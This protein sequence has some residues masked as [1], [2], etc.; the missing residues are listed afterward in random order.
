MNKFI[1]KIKEI[2]TKWVT[3]YLLFPALFLSFG[4]NAQNLTIKGKVIDSDGNTLPGVAILIKGSTVGAVTNDDGDY[5]LPNVPAGSA[6]EY[7][8]QGYVTQEQKATADKT[9][10]VVILVEEAQTLDD[11]TVVAFGTQKKATV[12]A[13]VETVKVSDLKVPA[14]N[15]TSA[16]AGRIPGI[17]SYQTSGEPGADNAQF[18]VRG[19]T[20]FG[21]G[22]IDPLILI[23]GFEASNDDLARIQPDDVESFSVLKDASATSVYG[24]RGANG[25]IMVNTKTGIEGAVRINARVDTHVATPSMTHKYVDAIT[26]M[27]MY[28]EARITRNPLMGI[29]YDEQK[30]QSTIN[31]ENSM[32]YPNVDWYKTLFN[33]S[34]VN[35]KANLNVS[36]GGKVATYYVAGGYD[37]E[38]GLLKVDSR[39]NFNSNIDINRFH[40][41]NN[42]IFKLSS[43]TTLDTRLQARYEKYTGPYKSATDIFGS[44]M[45]SNPVDFPAIFEP[46][47]ANLHTNHTLFGN[48]F[49]DGGL[50]GNP[51]AEMVSG[52]SSKDESN[53][54]VMATL[55]QDFDFLVKGLKAQAKFSVNTWSSYRQSRGF[56][57]YYY[58]IESYNQVTKEYKLLPLNEEWGNPL[59]SNVFT[60][61]QSTAH[62]YYEGRLNWDRTFG[63]HTLSAMM[64]GRA[65]EILLTTET[66]SIYESLPERN[67]GV[68]G[69]FSYDYDS[70][71]R[72]EF[73]FGYN[74]SEKFT[75]SNRFGLFPSIG[76]AWTVSNE[77][78]MESL[79]D[80]VSNLKLRFTYGKVGNDAIAGR[81]GRFW[82]L[83]DVGYGSYSDEE[84]ITDGYRWGET[85]TTSYLGYTVKRYANPDITWETSGIYN[86]AFELG[87]FKD[88]NLQVEYFR[89]VRDNIYMVRKNYAATSGLTAEVSGNVGRAKSQGIDASLDIQHS[90][91]K[92]FWVTGRVNFTYSV[93]EFLKLDEPRYRDEY[94]S[95]VGRNINLQKG[96]I[97]ER[98]FVD[99]MEIANVPKQDF[100]NYGAGDIKYT[101]VN[102]DGVVNSNDMVYMGYPSVPE[103]QYGFGLSTGYKN[104]DFSFFFSGN[105]RVSFYIAPE[106]IAPFVGRRNALSI[107]GND[108]WTETDPDVHSF[109]PRLSTEPITNNTQASSWWMRNG[110]FLRLKQLELGYSFGELERLKIKNLRGYLSAENVFIIS[111]FK[112]WDPEMGDNGLGYPI[113]RRFNVG[114]QVSF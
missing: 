113:Q 60:E 8:L 53:V 44:V 29:Y 13:S 55:M 14:S 18:F 111:P 98:L 24:A 15:L 65:E 58:D 93:N 68:S 66:T 30:I 36:G 56:T 101:D 90:F 2:K 105:A 89:N 23:D 54:T 47:A 33:S 91:N 107:V 92:D 99:D 49:I 31:G 72:A 88:F 35:T 109:W 10:I 110:N 17:I 27:R 41:R 20:T 94:L 7:K 39:N 76:L 114:I 74:G 5:S 102:G 1:V 6:L 73:S 16:F 51:Y 78:F 19:V 26:Y 28:N 3:V 70:R 79:S 71:Y 69:R 75:G 61:H 62:Y 84:F 4:L 46:D 104:L 34:T 100:G 83:S 97:A 87:L 40:L 21:T 80:V 52:Y 48:T 43:S 25:I 86:Y 12:I 59:L 64:V 106:K 67:V 63:S 108:Y 32:I 77:S 38:T 95:Q 9:T 82:F 81:G 50:K 11:V 112:L 45:N 85:F 37:K 42:V 22:K 96:L 103:I 57:P